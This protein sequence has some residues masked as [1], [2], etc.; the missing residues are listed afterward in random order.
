MKKALSVML[1]AALVVVSMAA[2]TAK[3]AAT[4]AAP[5]APAA[6]QAAPAATQAA[7]AATQA[8]APAAEGGLTVSGPVTLDIVTA[9]Q[10]TSWYSYGAIFAELIGKQLPSGS[11][12]TPVS[13]GG[14]TSNPIQVSKGAYDVGI[15]YN[16][17]DKWALEGDAI[18]TEPYSNLRGLAGYLDTFYYIAVVSKDAGWTDF[19]EVAEKHLPIRISCLPQG[20]MGCV[21]TEM[22]LNWY[23]MTFDDIISWGGVVEYADW[24]TSVENIKDGR[25]D[26]ICHNITQGHAAMTELTS[27]KDMYF[28]QFPKE[29]VDEFVANKGFSPETL[30]ADCFKGQTN[31]IETFGVTSNLFCR[32][33]LDEAVAY[34]IAKALCENEADVNAGH[35]A[36]TRF[37]AAA[38]AD[39]AGL[40]LPLHPGA[41]KYYKEV[42]ILK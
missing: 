9:G 4:T 7:P 3:P 29:M 21:I 13:E 36:L 41:E 8:A 33:D 6:S 22:I 23:G 32:E 1:A 42:G 30:P 26:F 34:N 17:V 35:K 10:G 11:I 39:P 37:K 2:C 14:A 15:G 38:A 24:T 12:V 5:A 31:A 18:Y 28:I 16:L 25:T 27:T 19:K 40:G 20:N